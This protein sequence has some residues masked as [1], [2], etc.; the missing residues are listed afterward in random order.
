M[1]S[2]LGAEMALSTV[3]KGLRQRRPQ[4]WAHLTSSKTSATRLTMRSTRLTDVIR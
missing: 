4:V 2:L 1:V 3:P